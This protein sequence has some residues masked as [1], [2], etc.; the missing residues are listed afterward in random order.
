MFRKQ[1]AAVLTAILVLSMGTACANKT[2][3]TAF[4]SETNEAQAV[5]ESSEPAA[6]E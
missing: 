3:N 1:I 4:P 2:P 5:E 6:E